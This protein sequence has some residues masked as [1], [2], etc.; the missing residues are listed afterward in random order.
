MAMN[1]VI[2]ENYWTWID[3]EMTGLDPERHVIIEM[4]SLITDVQLNVLAEGP[5]VAVHQPETFLDAMDEW[6]IRTHNQS[7]LIDRVRRS[8]ISLE[9][10]EQKV[11]EFVKQ[12]VPQGK[13]PLCGNSICQ[14]RR[15]LIRYMPELAGWFH[16]RNIDVSSLKELARHW[17]PH[18][19]AGVQKTDS[20]QAL[21]DIRESVK[22]LRHYREGLFKNSFGGREA[23]PAGK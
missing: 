5:V 12:W 10:A 20:H 18:V 21:D 7:G 15:F 8:R 13:S 2:S 11:L 4:A 23:R 14:D 19:L 9:Q 22:E 17:A 3:L 6:N 16:Y 1:P